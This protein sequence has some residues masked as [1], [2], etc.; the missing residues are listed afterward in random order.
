MEKD[1][2]ERSHRALRCAVAGAL[3]AAAGA[4]CAVAGAPSAC[5]SA[6]LTL[7]LYAA[8]RMFFALR[9]TT[10]RSAGREKTIHFTLVRG[11]VQ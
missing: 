5:N 3:R 6:P 9:K 7:P 11:V 1:L 2:M 4:R 8:P 10:L